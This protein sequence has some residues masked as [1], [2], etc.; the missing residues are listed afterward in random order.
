MVFTSNDK[1]HKKT[2]PLF[3]EKNQIFIKGQDLKSNLKIL[4]D[5]YS[6]FPDDIKEQAIMKF[7]VY[8]P[9]NTAPLISELWDRF[10]PIWRKHREEKKSKPPINEDYEKDMVRNIKKNLKKAVPVDNNIQLTTDN[11][12]HVLFKRMVLIKKGKWRILPHEVEKFI[13]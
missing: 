3:M 11:A 6:S 7:A 2:A 8:P 5:Y 9:E 13:N 12:D 10:L 1:L 4:D